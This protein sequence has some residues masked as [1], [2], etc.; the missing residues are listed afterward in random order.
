[1]E[2]EI[3]IMDDNQNEIEISVL[4]EFK[5]NELEKE[6]IMYSIID[7]DNSVTEGRVLI[8]EVIRKDDKVQVVGIKEE[9]K[10]LVLAFYNEISKQIEN[11]DE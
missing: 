10:D 9:E 3:V 11:E 8:G 7:R 4:G 1:M 5:I 6:Y 2:K